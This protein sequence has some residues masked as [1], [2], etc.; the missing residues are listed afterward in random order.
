VLS[1]LLTAFRQQY[2]QGSLTSDLLTIYDGLFVVRVTASA[3]GGLL[4]QSLAAHHSLETAEDNACQRALERLGLPSD[5]PTGISGQ[6]SLA[7]P[8]PAS[9]ETVP[10]TELPPTEISPTEISPTEI[11]PAPDPQSSGHRTVGSAQSA[12]TPDEP[13]V[14]PAPGS[15]IS[16][17]PTPRPAVSPEPTT[18]T[19]PEPQVPNG[20]LSNHHLT[21]A[22][23]P[24][25]KAPPTDSAPSPQPSP[26]DPM[27]LPATGPIDL[28]DI[29]AQTDVE[30]QRLGWDVHKGREFLEKTY[31][32]R[33]RHDLSDEELLEFL[34]YL[35]TQ[36]PES[37]N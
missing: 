24:V 36:T 21:L 14:A 37:V 18:T 17:M 7:L 25:A 30:L 35:E 23:P 4:A 20:N 2:P 34:L 10:P 9:P 19:R 28:S 33:S 5:A 22:T 27:V 13:V 29:I 26:T 11:P 15:P 6:P 31:G 3:N 12:E 32:K 8:Q 16:A 1:S